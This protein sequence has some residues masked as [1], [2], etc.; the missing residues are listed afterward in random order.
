MRAVTRHAE[1]AI[2]GSALATSAPAPATAQVTATSNFLTIQALRGIA[3]L[4][5]VA[6]HAFDMW[7]VRVEPAAG[8]SWAN[9]AAGVDIF[10]VISGF[11][12]V[13]SSRRTASQPG[14]GWTFIEHRMVRV[15]PLYWLLTTAKLILVFFLADLA[16]RSSL[17]LN[18][19]VRSYLF[20]PVVDSAG[21]FRPLLPVG[22]TLTYEFLFYL[23]FALALA[24]RIDVLR[25]LAPGLGLFVVLA[26]L[27]TN[28]WPAWTILFNTIIVEFIFGVLLAKLMLRGWQL[29]AWSAACLAVSGFAL[30]V[31]VPVGSENLRALTWGL[32][33]LA[34]VA[35]AVFLERRVAKMIP[36]WLLA[37]GDAS[38]SIYLTHGFVVAVLGVVFAFFQ[39][40]GLQ[41]E[42]VAVAAC[43]IASTAVGT[44]V[45][46]RVERPSMQFLKRRAAIAA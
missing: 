26:L 42:T 45:Y 15:V 1:I 39:S 24:L 2:A 34:V 41:A 25:V 18:Y 36:R 43:L 11:V 12:M 32:P 33:A 38:Y 27:K 17:D 16:L 20:L 9:G 7:A 46:Q 3:A 4:L 6:Y 44:V 19:I 28:S 8:V 37:Q 31:A 30:I 5:V 22:W 14:A 35:G 23:L 29:P 10:F 21:H 40:S 13:V